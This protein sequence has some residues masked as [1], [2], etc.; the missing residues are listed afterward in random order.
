MLSLDLVRIGLS[1]PLGC[2]QGAELGLDVDDPLGCRLF[3]KSTKALFKSFQVVAEPYASY[4][5][6]GYQNARFSELV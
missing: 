5:A 1:G 2:L 6:A 4:T 3:F